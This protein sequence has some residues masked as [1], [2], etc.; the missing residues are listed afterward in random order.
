MTSSSYKHFVANGSKSIPMRLSTLPW[1][2]YMDGQKDSTGIFQ[3]SVNKDV[4]MYQELYKGKTG[5]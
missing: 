5:W 1:C 3:D 2:L 4:Q